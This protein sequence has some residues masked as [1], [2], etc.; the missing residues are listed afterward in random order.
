VDEDRAPGGV[1]EP[2]A[3]DCGDAMVRGVWHEMDG[4][5][6]RSIA[7]GDQPPDEGLEAVPAGRWI[8]IR[9]DDAATG[10]KWFRTL[11]EN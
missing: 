3:D 1:C 10:T 5:V 2:D 4:G 8:G 6:Y 7:A 9:R 11:A